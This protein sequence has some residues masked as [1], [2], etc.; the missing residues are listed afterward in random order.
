MV[1]MEW[2]P[3]S[4]RCTITVLT[5]IDPWRSFALVR[6]CQ[7]FWLPSDFHSVSQ[8]SSLWS[9]RR[10]K[11]WEVL[12]S[13]IRRFIRIYTWLIWKV[14]F[15]IL[16]GAQISWSQM[17]YS[18]RNISVHLRKQQ[19]VEWILCHWPRDS[20]VLS[21]GSPQIRR[22]QI[23]EIQTFVQGGNMASSWG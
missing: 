11:M 9:T 4:R 21:A 5:T 13:R 19:S 7:E 17:R 10:M 2:Y 16:L 12:G 20:K 8:I 6:E 22:L 1:V 3:S 15:L 18:E 23:R 14:I